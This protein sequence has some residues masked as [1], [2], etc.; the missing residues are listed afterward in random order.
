MRMIRRAI[1]FSLWSIADVMGRI[2]NRIWDF[3]EDI[4][5]SGYKTV[6]PDARDKDYNDDNELLCACDDCKYENVERNDDRDDL[7]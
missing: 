1:A 6:E 2:Q 7:G 3:G 4:L 5:L